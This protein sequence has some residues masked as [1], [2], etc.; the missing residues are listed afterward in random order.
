MFVF[1]DSVHIFRIELDSFCDSLSPLLTALVKADFFVM[2]KLRALFDF[3]LKFLF[4]VY[5]LIFVLHEVHSKTSEQQPSLSIDTLV[6]L[7][8]EATVLA[9]CSYRG[10]SFSDGT[11]HWSWSFTSGCCRKSGCSSEAPSSGVLY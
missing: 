3:H 5:A 2:P 9:F 7:W 6:Y 11:I 8:F 10:W 1:L 4:F